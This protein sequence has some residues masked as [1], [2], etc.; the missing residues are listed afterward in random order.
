MRVGP[1]M[2]VPLGA[3]LL[4]A[5][6]TSGSPTPT[7]TPGDPLPESKFVPG[8]N[9]SYMGLVLTGELVLGPDGCLRLDPVPA[10]MASGV[11]DILWP[12]GTTLRMLPSGQGEVV[13]PDGTVVATTGEQFS[14]SGGF[15]S[16]RAEPPCIGDG[17]AF[18]LEAVLEP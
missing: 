16:H 10:S 14:A 8:P 4:A 2:A 11:T 7:F 12:V 18:Q 9:A 1:W 3:L 17:G 15:T 13:W 6:G 5:C